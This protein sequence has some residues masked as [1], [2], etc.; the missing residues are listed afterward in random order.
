MLAEQT[1]GRGENRKA[2]I[3]GLWV[4]RRAVA[5]S[6]DEEMDGAHYGARSSK[7]LKLTWLVSGKARA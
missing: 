4:A 1:Q 3:R 2:R 5:A 6:E 7:S